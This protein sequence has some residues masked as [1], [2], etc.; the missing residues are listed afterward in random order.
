MTNIKRWR[1]NAT[2]TTS[3][4]GAQSF[5]TPLLSGYLEAIRYRR[6]IPNGTTGIT[7]TS[8]FSTNAHIAITG[9]ISGINIWEATSTDDA[10][11][12][13]R[14]NVVSTANVALGFSSNATPPPIPTRI[15]LGQERI[16]V[17]VTSG[18]TASNGGT[19]A[20]FDF[21]IEGGG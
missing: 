16:K 9:E 21:Y 17:T 4:G 20:I 3:G 2:Y 8:G 7:T 6:G 11:W 15:P 14:A 1:V 5:H 19:R 12:Y 18:G 13:P 10:P